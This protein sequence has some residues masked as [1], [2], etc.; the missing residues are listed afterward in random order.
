MNVVKCISGSR[1]KEKM[2]M[3]VMGGGGETDKR[4][5]QRVIHSSGA[6]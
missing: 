1:G 2:F 4:P 3:E 5:L 6:E